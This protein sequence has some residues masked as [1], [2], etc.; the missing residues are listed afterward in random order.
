[1]KKAMLFAVALLFSVGANAASLGLTGIG[2]NG[3]S[4]NV[5]VNNN[6]VV[7]AGGTVGET[8]V[9]SSLFDLTT[10][11]DTNVNIEWSFNPFKALTG[12]QIVFGQISG[13][14]GYYLPGSQ[15]FDITG[16]F[17]FTAFLTEGLFYGLDII[18]ASSSV[19][20]YDLSVSAV[21]VPAALFL[22]APVLLGFLGLRRKSAVAA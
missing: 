6:S 21:P 17:S 11:T 3:A 15:V 14:N 2:S 10:D 18:N 1:M 13:P 22:F 8:S 12:A 7:L 20:K 9:W 5:D 4:Q 19:L 16:D